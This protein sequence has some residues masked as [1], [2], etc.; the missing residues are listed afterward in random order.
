MSFRACLFAALILP[1]AAVAAHS[2]L[3]VENS[4]FERGAEEFGGAIMH[5]HT[6]ITNQC[7]SAFNAVVTVEF[8]S[9]EG[10]ALESVQDH[11][12]LARRANQRIDKQTFLS[13]DS[14]DRVD[15]IVV[16]LEE[17]ERPY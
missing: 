12:I 15:T 17:R 7:D 6:E 10:E 16:T 13:A 8:Q 9:V 4:G 11:A 14:A 3:S 5:W 2:C 1:S